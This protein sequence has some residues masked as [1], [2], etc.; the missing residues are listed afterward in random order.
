MNIAFI[1]HWYK[2]TSSELAGAFAAED[3]L[4]K[5][6]GRLLDE[7]YRAVIF[8]LAKEPYTTGRIFNERQG[9]WYSLVFNRETL[10]SDVRSFDPDVVFVNHHPRDYDDILQGI[11]ELRAKKVIYYSAP[12]TLSPLTKTFDAF[13][14][15]H[16]CQAGELVN[17]GVDA[18]K[19]H[20]APK[21][22]DLDCFCPIEGT[23]KKWDCIYPARGRFG[24]WKRIELAVEA[25]GLIGATIVLPGAEI[26][27]T[28]NRN[29]SPKQQRLSKYFPRLW[30][31]LALRIGKLQG[32]PWVTTLSWRAPEELNMCYNQ[33]RCLVITSD[34]TEVGP[35]VIP[36]AAACNLP[37]VCCS[38]SRA[39]VSHASALGGYIAAPNPRDVASKIKMALST[40]PNSRK[41]LIEKGLDTWVIYRVIRGLLDEWKQ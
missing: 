31:K 27:G 13:L 1:W 37:I 29:P 23:T 25:C 12:I 20:V 8:A 22:A 28:L 34:D 9:T 10:V 40:T 21:T 36:E 19:V 3:T 33:S 15:H 17:F 11:A 38:D 26:P 39:C 35:R 2:R 7:G 6:I 18:S 16:A 32:F 5:A 4:I 24:Y 30:R 14:V 41:K